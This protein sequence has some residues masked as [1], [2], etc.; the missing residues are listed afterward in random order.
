MRVDQ[1]I[2]RTGSGRVETPKGQDSGHVFM[3]VFCLIGQM[4]GVK[5]QKQENALLPPQCVHVCNHIQLQVLYY[6]LYVWMQTAE[7]IKDGC[8]SW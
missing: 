4:R 5:G 7:H 2:S 1:H 3:I 8:K 6:L